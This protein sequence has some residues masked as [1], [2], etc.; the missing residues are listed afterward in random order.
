MTGITRR[1]ALVS[2]G[3]AVAVAG[4]PGAVQA[5]PVVALVNK[6]LAYRDQINNG[7]DDMSDDRLDALCE[8]LDKMLDLI[9]LTPAT[10]VQGIAGKVR[11][12]WIQTVPTI[13][14]E[15]TGPPDE[16]DQIGRL[17]SERFIWSALQ[18]LERLAV[19][20]ERQIGGMRP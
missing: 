7:P 6:A 17:A 9:R 18:D 1:A 2:A 16:F 14:A 3:A 5:D 15:R 8:P 13:G 12:A 19:D 11:V 10:S 4:V 20:F